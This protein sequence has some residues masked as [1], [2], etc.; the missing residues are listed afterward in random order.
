MSE[1][2]EFQCGETLIVRGAGGFSKRKARFVGIDSQ[3]RAVVEDDRQI[4]SL[5]MDW[6]KRPSPETWHAYEWREQ[7]RGV[8]VFL[9]PVGE[10]DSYLEALAA[11][12]DLV[13]PECGVIVQVPN[14]VKAREHD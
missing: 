13:K 6:L 2:T 11:H 1:K 9:T 3:G 7:Y 14:V 4:Y 8:D 5:E 12:P 10:Y